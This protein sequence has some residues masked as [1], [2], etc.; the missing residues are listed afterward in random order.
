VRRDEVHRRV[1]GDAELV[2]LVGQDV[3]Q[4]GVAEQRLRR[5]APD[6]E[7]DPAPVLLLDDRDLLAQL[8]SPDRGDVPTRAGT[9]DDDVE[10]LLSHAPN[11]SRRPPA[12]PPP[13]SPSLPA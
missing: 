11:A 10:V 4:L 7:A 5:D 12:L 2:L 9:E 8:G 1:A 13:G 6:V 3:R